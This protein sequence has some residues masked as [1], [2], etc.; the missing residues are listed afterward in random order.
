[1]LE[2]I[3]ILTGGTAIMKD[4]GIELDKVEMDHLGIA[5]KVTSTTTTRRSSKGGGEVKDIQ[6][7]IARSARRS[8][9]D[10]RLRSARSS[11]SASRSSR[12]AWR[13]ST[14]APRPNRS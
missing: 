3:A 6:G 5:K 7:R 13:R 12:A 4:L 11:R 1:M 2:D 14:S 9:H 10:Q 8:R